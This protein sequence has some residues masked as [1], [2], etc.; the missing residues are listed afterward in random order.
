MFRYSARYRFALQNAINSSRVVPNRKT[1]SM[2]PANAPRPTTIPPTSIISH[3]LDSNDPGE[4]LKVEVSVS[5]LANPRYDPVAHTRHR[6][7]TIA[8]ADVPVA[9]G[10]ISKS[11]SVGKKLNL[12]RARDAVSVNTEWL[13]ILK[14][15]SGKMKAVANTVATSK[16]DMKKA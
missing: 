2:R 11:G 4:T 3:Y 7:C 5:L 14:N 16:G 15:A 13:E 1:L 8:S 6:G 10:R 9:L 12:L